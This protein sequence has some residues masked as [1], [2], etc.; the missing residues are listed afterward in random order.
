[1]A[2][3]VRTLAELQALLA[4]N[5]SGQI[6]P[7]DLR[8]LM[9]TTYTIAPGTEA[10]PGLHGYFGGVEDTDTGLWVPAANTLA[11]STAGSE[12]YAH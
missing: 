12:A 3:T 7:Q 9:V 1:M 10:L 2:D 5:T 4:D 11:I 6:S 8:D